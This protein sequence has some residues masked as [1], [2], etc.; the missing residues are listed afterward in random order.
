MGVIHKRCL[1]FAMGENMDLSKFADRWKKLSTFGR[2]VLNIKKN[3]LTSFMN[4]D[5]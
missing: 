2:E 4:D 5:P 1:K 3:F